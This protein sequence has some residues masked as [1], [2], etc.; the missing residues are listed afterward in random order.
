MI[1]ILLLFLFSS[2]ANIPSETN[3]RNDNSLI[4]PGIGAERVLIN[5]NLR[6][7]VSLLGSPESISRFDK[8][9]ELFKTV[10]E[11]DSPRKIFFDR[12][13]YYKQQNAIILCQKGFVSGIIGLVSSR[14]TTE[15]VSLKKGVEYFIFN[16]GNNELIALSG[17]SNKKRDMIYLF[18]NLGLAIGDDGDDDSIDFYIVFGVY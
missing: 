6:R 15:S 4:I 11:N 5:D 2:I 13:Y 8:T 1:S 7:V 16:Y 18:N 14:I 10:F 3:L 12:L 9:Q 17:R